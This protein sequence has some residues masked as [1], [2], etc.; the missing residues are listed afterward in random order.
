MIRRSGSSKPTSCTISHPLYPSKLFCFYLLFVCH[1][2]SLPCSIVA[3]VCCNPFETPCIPHSCLGPPSSVFRCLTCTFDQLLRNRSPFHLYARF[4]L[5][6]SFL[7]LDCQPQCVIVQS[8]VQSV[9]LWP[10]KKPC[11]HALSILLIFPYPESTVRRVFLPSL[12]HR[13]CASCRG[14][15]E[16]TPSCCRMSPGDQVKIGSRFKDSRST[17]AVH[18]Y[19]TCTGGHQVQG[20]SAPPDDVVLSR[21]WTQLAV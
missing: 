17:A 1:I 13:R 4:V 20:V 18:I 14:T 16:I 6:S 3:I 9:E 19:N 15:R 7:S 8:V 5:S 21:L 11:I 2:L 10:N 12:V